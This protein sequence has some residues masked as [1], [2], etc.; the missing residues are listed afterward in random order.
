MHSSSGALAVQELN[1]ARGFIHSASRVDH[2]IPSGKRSPF[3]LRSPFL[4]R[5]DADDCRYIPANLGDVH[6]KHSFGKVENWA[7]HCRMSIARMHRSTRVHARQERPHAMAV[8]AVPLFLCD[9]QLQLFPTRGC[10]TRV[11]VLA[12]GTAAA[13][14]S[15]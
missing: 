5:Q 15:Q 8:Y 13:V 2:W 3:N 10:L 6:F 12:G 11:E 14:N 9:S 1:E 7:L 4:V